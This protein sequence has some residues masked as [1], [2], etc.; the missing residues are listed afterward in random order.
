[1]ATCTPCA[2]LAAARATPAC[3]FATVVRCLVEAASSEE[4]LAGIQGRI[5]MRCKRMAVCALPCK[6]QGR[7]RPFQRT[8]SS[9]RPRQ[10]R[11]ATQTEVASDSRVAMLCAAWYKRHKVGHPFTLQC[12]ERRSVGTT[13]SRHKRNPSVLHAVLE[14]IVGGHLLVLV[15]DEVR[16]HARV[17]VK[18]QGLQALNGRHLLL[19]RDDGAPLPFLRSSSP[20]VLADSRLPRQLTCVS[21]M[22]SAPSMPSASSPP[23]PRIICRN[24]C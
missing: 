18:A 19:Q 16:L 11:K 12:S 5:G 8:A 24:S 3:L 15:A 14:E 6:R 4:R 9:Y 22:V 10:C 13:P 20:Q 23:S 1:M 17:A 7:R 21:S 2:R